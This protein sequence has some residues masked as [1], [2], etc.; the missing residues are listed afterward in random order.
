MVLEDLVEA[1]LEKALERVA[2]E[3]RPGALP[4]TFRTLLSDDCPHSTDETLVLGRADLI[5]GSERGVAVSGKSILRTCMLHFVTS[6]GVMPAWVVP[7]ASPPPS[8]QTV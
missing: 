7:H 8:M 2:K 1:V 6:T 3:R 4:E 5:G